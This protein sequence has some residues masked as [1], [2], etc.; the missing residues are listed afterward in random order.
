MGAPFT[1][2]SCIQQGQI[3]PHRSQFRPHFTLNLQVQVLT[4]PHHMI[5]SSVLT[6][7]ITYPH[8]VCS[9]AQVCTAPVV[10]NLRTPLTAWDL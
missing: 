4:S 1:L 7:T 5:G 2:R 8:C 10:Q 9:F 3:G 6:T